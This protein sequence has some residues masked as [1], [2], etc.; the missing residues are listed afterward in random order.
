MSAH[1]LSPAALQDL[2]DILDFISIDNASAADKLE[3]E[4]F[5]AFERLAQRPRM[6]HSRTDLTERDVLFWLVGSYLNCLPS[7]FNYAA[8]CRR[9]AWS[10]RRH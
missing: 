5:E 9:P 2:Q 4:F 1:V 7:G 6:G 10:A 8:D 3:V